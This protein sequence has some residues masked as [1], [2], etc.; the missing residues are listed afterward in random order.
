MSYAKIRLS[1]VAVTLAYAS[2]AIAGDDPRHVRHELMESVGKAAKPVG[3]MLKGERDFDAEVLMSSLRTF[4]DAAGRFGDLFPDD[5][6]TGED[7]EAAPAIWEDRAGFEEALARWQTA[8]ADAIAAQPDTLDAARPVA[9][10]V[11]Q[12]C[13]ACHESYRID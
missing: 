13:K 3:N 8:V 7:T 5:S 6:R 12:A 11:F 1:L 10:P 9:E 4:E 2:L